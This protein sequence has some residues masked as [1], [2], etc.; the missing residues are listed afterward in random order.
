MFCSQ[1]GKPVEV[2][3]AFCPSCGNAV[4][5]S[6]DGQVG[7]REKAKI[8]PVW[9]GVLIFGSAFLALIFMWLNAHP[10]VAGP[11]ASYLDRQAAAMVAPAASEGPLR[12]PVPGTI[13]TPRECGVW[14]SA[15]IKLPMVN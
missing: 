1:C 8:V 13:R 10:K 5:S 6:A 2:G 12:G 4:G 3:Q 14:R 11:K 9:L 15:E 7:S